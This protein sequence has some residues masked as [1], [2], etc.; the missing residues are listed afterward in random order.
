MNFTELKSNLLLA[1]F[2]E[3]GLT[4]PEPMLGLGKHGACALPLHVHPQQVLGELLL[5]AEGDGAPVLPP[6]LRNGPVEDAHSLVALHSGL[7]IVSK[8]TRLRDSLT[9]S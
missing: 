7:A 8:L 1:L 9:V 2:M 6:Q 3:S 5:L 4:V